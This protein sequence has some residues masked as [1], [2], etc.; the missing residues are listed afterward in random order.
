MEYALNDSYHNIYT[1]R[2]PKGILVNIITPLNRIESIL[3]H[4]KPL[5]INVIFR[6]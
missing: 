3:K 1:R 5:K 4:M 6:K 2:Q